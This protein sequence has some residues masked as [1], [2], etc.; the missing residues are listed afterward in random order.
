MIQRKQN[1]TDGSTFT[2]EAG[3][4][5]TDEFEPKGGIDAYLDQVTFLNYVE[6]TAVVAA[7][8]T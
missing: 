3:P 8:Y 2:Y 6:S 7:H 5:A 4:N 1:G